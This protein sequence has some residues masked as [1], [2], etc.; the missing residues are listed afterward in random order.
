VRGSRR[1]ALTAPG[2]YCRSAFGEI[3]GKGA[4]KIT[5]QAVT[6]TGR[7][8]SGVARLARCEAC[9]STCGWMLGRGTDSHR[10][11]RVGH[12]AA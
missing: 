6:R 8:A 2:N 5:L 3:V 4:H 1:I 11:V 12:G 10:P 9:C 7:L